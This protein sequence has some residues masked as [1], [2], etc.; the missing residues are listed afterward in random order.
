MNVVP[1]WQPASKWSRICISSNCKVSIFKKHSFKDILFNIHINFK[2]LLW[3]SFKTFWLKFGWFLNSVWLG[4]R[5]ST[6]NHLHAHFFS[7]FTNFG[8]KVSHNRR[9]NARDSNHAEKLFTHNES[10]TLDSLKFFVLYAKHLVLL[11]TDFEMN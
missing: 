5:L 6:G 9:E 8:L 7:I 10:P 4:G 3:I 1:S 2:S 11:I